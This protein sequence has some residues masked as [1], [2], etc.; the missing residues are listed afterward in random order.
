[1]TG[2]LLVAALAGYALLASLLAYYLELRK[3]D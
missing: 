2:G 1:M 3:R